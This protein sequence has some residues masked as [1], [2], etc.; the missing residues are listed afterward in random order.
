MPGKAR[1]AWHLAGGGAAA[2]AAAEEKDGSRCQA[3]REALG[4]W[5]GAARLLVLWPRRR[6]AAGASQGER[7]ATPAVP[8]ATNPR[9]SPGPLP[10][11]LVRGD[12]GENRD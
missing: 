7:R 2:G 3:R 12:A 11:G 8:A 1:G 10:G 5:L 6:T 9:G 4:T